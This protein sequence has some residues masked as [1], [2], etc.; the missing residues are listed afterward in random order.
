MISLEQKV[1]ALQMISV[2]KLT[3][4]NWAKDWYEQADLSATLALA[5]GEGLIIL[6]DR[7]LDI[8]NA[9]WELAYTSLGQEPEEMY[10]LLTS[11][12]EYLEDEEEE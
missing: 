3:G 12:D 10:K 1:E 7:G 9:G 4:D 2:L 8:I 5:Y 6:T 11:G